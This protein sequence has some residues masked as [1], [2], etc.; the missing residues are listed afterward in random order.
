MESGHPSTADESVAYGPDP[1]ERRYA[2]GLVDEIGDRVLI[3]DE[4]RTPTLELLRFRQTLTT[5]PGFE[6]ALRRRVE[7]LRPFRHE[8]FADPPGVEYL[9]RD[10]SLALLSN[11][12]PGRR[13]SDLL[14][15]A[16]DPVLAASLIHQLTPALHALTEYSEGVGHGALTASRIV[17]APDGQLTII[18]YVLGSAVERLHLT[19]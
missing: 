5:S 9:G 11:Y 10:R 14:A 8:A 13:L 17:S 4:R 12:T 16:Q 19:A 6:V 1:A 7:R 2:P 18:E 3:L 15:H